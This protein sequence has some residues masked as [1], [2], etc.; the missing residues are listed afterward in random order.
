MEN[1]EKYVLWPG[2]GGSKTVIGRGMGKSL[3]TVRGAQE[4]L[5][6]L[7]RFFYS[8][9]YF[10]IATYAIVPSSK[11]TGIPFLLTVSLHTNSGRIISNETGRPLSRLDVK[12]PNEKTTKTEE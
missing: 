12:M 10:F 8:S 5:H 1:G 6:Y 9:R 4:W 2:C 11:S 3:Y 7:E